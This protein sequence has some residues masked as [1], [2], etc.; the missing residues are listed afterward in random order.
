MQISERLPS[1]CSLATDAVTV[2]YIEV[3]SLFVNIISP[4]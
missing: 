3:S 1:E 2:H 4:E